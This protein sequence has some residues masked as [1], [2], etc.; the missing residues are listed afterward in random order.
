MKSVVIS[1]LF[2]DKL[3]GNKAH[4]RG[5]CSCCLGK[6]T[7]RSGPWKTEPIV[8]TSWLKAHSYRGWVHEPPDMRRLQRPQHR[9]PL[10]S[11]ELGSSVYCLIPTGPSYL[12]S[13]STPSFV[14]TSGQKSSG[15]RKAIVMTFVAKRQSQRHGWSLFLW[16]QSL[17]EER[18]WSGL[19]LRAPSSTFLG[20]QGCANQ[21]PH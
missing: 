20:D 2:L 13:S 18:C 9:A 16:S 3:W 19:V 21:L 11:A 6:I 15:A 12:L 17:A 1:F 10:I 5:R 14:Q 4:P 7:G 8:F